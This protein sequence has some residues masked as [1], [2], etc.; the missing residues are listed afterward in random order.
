MSSAASGTLDLLRRLIAI[1][2]VNPELVPGAAGEAAA[3][4]FAAEWLAA[5]DVPGGFGVRTLEHGPGRTSVLAVARGTGGG[6]S[7]MLNGHLDTVALSSYDGDGLRPAERDGNLYGRGAYDMKSGVAAVMTAAAAAA[8]APH[9][10]D[11]VVALVADEE[12]ARPAPRRCC[13][14]W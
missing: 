8:A 12:W 2:S 5:R 13:A 10:G 11:I 14:R 9:R 4:R 7:L 1:D 6:R 3:A